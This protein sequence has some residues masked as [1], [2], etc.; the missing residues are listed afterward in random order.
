MKADVKQLTTTEIL[1]LSGLVFIA[2][3]IPHLSIALRDKLLPFREQLV[4]FD[5]NMSDE[6]AERELLQAV[7]NI[8]NG[9]STAPPAG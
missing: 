8:I 6:E 3:D 4:T 7:D 9:P 5:E 1:T 2:S